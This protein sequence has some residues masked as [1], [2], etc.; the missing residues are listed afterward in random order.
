LWPPPRANRIPPSAYD[1]FLLPI[2][3][4]SVGIALA[5]VPLTLIATTNV[6]A[7]DAGLTS[8]LLNTSQ[9]IGGS[10]GLAVLATLATS[11]SR[12]DSQSPAFERGIPA[13]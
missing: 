13:A 4:N 10:L 9:R 2:V 7:G 8:G 3:I 5:F 1:I 6:D 12:G 11:Q